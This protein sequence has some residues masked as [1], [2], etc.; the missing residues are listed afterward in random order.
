MIYDYISKLENS[1]DQ[2]FDLF[3]RA[4]NIDYNLLNYRFMFNLKY[5]VDVFIDIAP[6]LIEKTD[7]INLLS[8][9]TQEKGF[10]QDPFIDNAFNPC[11]F[12]VFKSRCLS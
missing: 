2:L 4:I 11:S 12:D 3:H 10:I 7:S 9:L 5:C 1:K 8:Y 6:N